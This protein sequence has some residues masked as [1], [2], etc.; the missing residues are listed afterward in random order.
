LDAIYSVC[1]LVRKVDTKKNAIGH[2]HARAS[3]GAKAW[4]PIAS[5]GVNFC[6]KTRTAHGLLLGRRGKPSVDGISTGSEQQFSVP[7]RTVWIWFP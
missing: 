4:E 5:S 2:T 3:S 6:R 1:E 7:S